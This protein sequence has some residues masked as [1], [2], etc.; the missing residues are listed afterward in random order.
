MVNGIA[1][2][3]VQTLILYPIH[4]V[5][6]PPKISLKIKSSIVTSYMSIY[7]NYFCLLNLTPI[8]TISISIYLMSSH[9][10]TKPIPSPAFSGE[11]GD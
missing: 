10:A 9:Y 1:K 6:T 8:F 7:S 3:A 4:D 5:T 2:P 11:E